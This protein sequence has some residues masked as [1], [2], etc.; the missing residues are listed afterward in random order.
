MTEEIWKGIEGYETLYQISN[1]GIVKSLDRIIKHKT[2]K[3]QPI[4]GLILKGDTNNAGYH[5][6]R[7]F[8]ISS[9]ERVF[10]HRL[11]AQTFIPNP[12]NLPCVN[13]KD[14]NKKNNR[15]DNLEWTNYPDN[16]KHAYS[17]GLA[18]HPVG[19]Q[20]HNSKLTETKV[21]AIRA[22][23]STVTQQSLADE[24]GVSRRAIGKILNRQNWKHI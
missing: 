10:V 15:V 14:G 22:K 19:E 11:V 17:T 23:G 1:Q 3:L 6:I 13:H 20:W 8:S 12:L 24:F 18:I 16:I 2:G 5:R 7:L 21:L 4:K 9:K